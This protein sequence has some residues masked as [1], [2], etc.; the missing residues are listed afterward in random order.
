MKWKRDPMEEDFIN[1]VLKK[2]MKRVNNIMDKK[3]KEKL[4]F[5]DEDDIFNQS[6]QKL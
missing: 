3:L 2:V 5:L 1:Q 6:C 4:A